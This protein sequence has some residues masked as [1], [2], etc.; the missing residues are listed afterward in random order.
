[1]DELGKKMRR[2]KSIGGLGF[3][4]LIM[5][6]KALL[7]KQGWRLIQNPDS[8]IAQVPRAKYFPR[9]SFLSSVV[10]TRPSFVWRSLLFAI[11]L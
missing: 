6:N 4:D 1:L 5:F 3:R 9:D 10:G 2:S 7:A 8:L 11:D